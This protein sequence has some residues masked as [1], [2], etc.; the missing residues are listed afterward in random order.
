M[1]A[2]EEL[3]MEHRGIEVMLRVMNAISERLGRGEPVPAPHLDGILEFL[4]VF[5]IG[6]A[7]V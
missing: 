4:T 5:K 2:V 3:K 1:K 7:H 6:R